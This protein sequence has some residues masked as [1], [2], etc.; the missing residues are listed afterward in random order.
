MGLYRQLKLLPFKLTQLSKN[1]KESSSADAPARV[2]S[3]EDAG[4]HELP[5]GLQYPGI[6]GRWYQAFMDI[7]RFALSVSTVHTFTRPYNAV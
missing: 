5:S 6:S 7:I 2:E 4:D 3:E 1:R